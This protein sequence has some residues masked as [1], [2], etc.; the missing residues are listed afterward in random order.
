MILLFLESYSKKTKKYNLSSSHVNSCCRFSIFG[1][2]RLQLGK[3][4]CQLPCTID[5]YFLFL[6]FHFCLLLWLYFC[7]KI[8]NRKFNFHEHSAGLVYTYTYLLTYS[9]I[10][11]LF[12]I[13]CSISDAALPQSVSSREVFWFWSTNFVILSSQLSIPLRDQKFSSL[14]FVC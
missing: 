3:D 13:F 4:L 9:N 12:H 7:G 14:S 2:C 6:Q 11:L 8:C 5:F 10:T 1:K